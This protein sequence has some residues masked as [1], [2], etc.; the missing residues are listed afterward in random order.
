MKKNLAQNF[1]YV[2][3]MLVITGK[4]CA[5]RKQSAPLDTEDR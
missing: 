2:W 5:W 1:G 3:T 4:G